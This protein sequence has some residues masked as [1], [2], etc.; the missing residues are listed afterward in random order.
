MKKFFLASLMGMLISSLAFGVDI[1]SQI[2][3][4]DLNMDTDGA[5]HGTF[6]R[7]TSTGGTITLDKIDGNQIPWSLDYLRTIRPHD[8]TGHSASPGVIENFTLG[9]AGYTD[10]VRANDLITK[11]P[12]VDVRAYMDGKSGRPTLAA[13][14]LN[15]WTYGAATTVDTVSAIQAA[16]DYALQN[17]INEVKMPDGFFRTT[18]PVHLGYGETFH[19]ITLNG[20]GRRY[21]SWGWAGGSGTSIVADFSNAPAINVQGGRS[22]MI[23]NLSLRGK[24]ADYAMNT[25]YTAI[26]TQNVSYDNIST[27]TNWVSGITDNGMTR[28]APYAAI[29]IDAY[30]SWGGGSGIP[31]I[32]YPTVVYPAWTGIGTT[33]YGKSL[34]S[35]TTI[36]NVDINGFFVGVAQTPSNSDG[37]GDFLKVLHSNITNCA[38]GVSV[39]QTQSRNVTI[40]DTEYA[41]VHTLITNQ[42]HGKRQGT[43][44]ALIKNVSGGVQY[45]IFQSNSAQAGSL[46]FVNFYAELVVRFGDTGGAGSS[47]SGINFESSAIAAIGWLGGPGYRYNVPLLAGSGPISFK[48]TQLQINTPFVMLSSMIG[49]FVLVE[50]SSWT[51]SGLNASLDNNQSLAYNWMIGGVFNPNSVLQ[52]LLQSGPINTITPPNPV[53]AEVNYTTTIIGRNQIHQYAKYVKT[54]GG[55]RIPLQME[56]VD[57]GYALGWGDAMTGGAF[58]NSTLV[59]T[60]KYIRNYVNHLR[61]EPGTI[62]Y[63]AP[64]N[65]IF[66]VDNVV[67]NSLYDDDVSATMVTNYW[68]DASNN[69]NI[70]IPFVTSG[71]MY[72]YQTFHK[73]SGNQF[74]GDVTSGSDNVTNI[75][76][77]DGLSYTLG[78]SFKVG[79]LVWNNSNMWDNYLPPHTKIIEVGP[80]NGSPS[81]LRL[82]QVATDNGTN[83]PVEL[84]R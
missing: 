64:M 68:V 42:V 24:S 16:V 63:S 17:H 66:I 54:L 22:C 67:N 69:K 65:A 47:N 79:D 23:K 10:N 8:I 57:S 36:Y 37:N 6:Q 26:N 40:Q 7:R 61:I 45:Q 72:P 38:Y 11:G 19:Q 35:A 75:R 28:Y 55:A 33:Q 51:T 41:G 34:S 43:L 14:W 5:A 82:D 58:D 73:S 3:T 70:V 25:Y 46:N 2:G 39:G 78:S 60:F 1:K 27:A 18:G 31:A 76:T 84:V 62:L 15:Q 77:P 44:D 80:S 13:W 83:V 53:P 48:N 56:R 12:W 20:S 29:T 71:Y 4:Q 49:P 21:T 81:W 50:Q 9:S 59:L 30:S 52:G 32:P 74:R